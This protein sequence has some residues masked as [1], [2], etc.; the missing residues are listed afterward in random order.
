MDSN[1]ENQELAASVKQLLMQI[2]PLK[3]LFFE[4]TQHCNLRCAHCGSRCP[5]YTGRSELSAENCRR[6]VDS[7]ARTYPTNQLM[8]CITGG[9]PLLN[10]EWFEICSYITQKGFSWGMTSNGT[11]IDE[12][13]VRRLA[14]AGMKTIAVSLDGLKESHER[15]RGVPGC[16]DQAVNAI[17]L[18]KNSGSFRAVQVVT[19]VNRMNIGELPQLYRLMESLQIDSWKLTPIEPM[20]KAKEVQALFLSPGEQYQL[21]AFIKEKRQTAPFDL[22]YGCSHLLPE[23]YDSTVRKQ[24]FL[25]GAGTMIASIASNGDILPCLDIDCRERVKQGNI[26]QDDFIDVWENKFELFRRNKANTSSICRD[27]KLKQVC[28]GDSWHSWNFEEEAPRVCFQ[29]QAFF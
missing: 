12:A 25:C 15:L 28:Q 1:Y 26:L 29:K 8:F 9:E 21:L 19:V 13:C 22:T 27:C 18:L 6:V 5:D 20:G 2:H 11:L 24:P 10:K 17:R 16:Y 3:Y 4:L 7:A 14:E 23:E